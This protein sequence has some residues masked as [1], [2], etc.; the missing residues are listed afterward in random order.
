MSPFSGIFHFPV[1]YY[2]RN[3]Q[4]RGC[5]RIYYG[6]TF[7]NILCI[8]ICIFPFLYSIFPAYTVKIVFLH[9]AVLYH[10]RKTKQYFFPIYSGYARRMES[11]FSIVTSS[12][13]PMKAI[14]CQNFLKN[15][16]FFLS[17]KTLNTIL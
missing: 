15:T 9:C 6:P 5:N 16:I 1:L 14:N 11:F 4:V 12:H 7:A 13:T 8:Y 3:A 10:A 2:T 17:L